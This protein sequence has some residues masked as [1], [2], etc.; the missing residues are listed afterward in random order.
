MSPS[1]DDFEALFRTTRDQIL[2]YLLRRCNPPEDAADLLGETYLVA[3]RHRHDLPVGDEA[4]VWLYGV[5]RRVLANHN[6]GALR[7]HNL[8]QRLR[9]QLRATDL[10]APG[11]EEHDHDLL[12][13]LRDA[14]GRLSDDD[15]E[16][17]Q[18]AAWEHLDTKQIAAVLGIRPGT[19]R[20]RLH[21]AR[22]RL[23]HHLQTEPS[24]PHPQTCVMPAAP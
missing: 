18:L 22:A 21:R 7:R 12:P 4:R 2:S 14:L 24:T 23:R 16:L 1:E 20:T 11:P 10:L 6:R 19:V 9:S 3:W 15:R 8:G 17:V 13:K 5:A